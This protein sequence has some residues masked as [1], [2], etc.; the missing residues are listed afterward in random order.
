MF[1]QN[2]S[3]Q[4]YTYAEDYH[5][6]LTYDVA[7]PG[8][9]MSDYI[10]EM[11]WAGMGIEIKRFLSSNTSVGF[12]FGWNIFDSR[13]FG[14]FEIGNGH[15]TGTQVRNINA[16]PFTLNFHYYLS[17]GSSMVPFIGLNA[18]AYYIFQK[19]QLGVLTLD[20]DN[21]HFGLAPE[22]GLEISLNRSLAFLV[23]A[24]YNYAFASGKKLNGED[25]IDYSYYGINV[26]FTF[27]N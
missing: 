17:T 11:S 14:T 12:F 5:F 8:T 4:M 3:A 6:N 7:I 15:V 20:N 23:S 1:C 25:G 18:G 9:G 10:D 2:A 21:W 16:F 19:F 24:K 27:M 26:G 22:A 13:E